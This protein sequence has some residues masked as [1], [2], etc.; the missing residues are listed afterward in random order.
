[1]ISIANEAMYN[2][3]KYNKINQFF[4]DCTYKM[5]PPNKNK[6][7]LMVL[8]GFN[9]VSKKLY[10]VRFVLLTNKKENTFKALF[11]IL[12]ENYHFNPRNIMC[13]FSLG[14]IKEVKEIYPYTNS[15]LFFSLF[16]SFLES[17]NE[18]YN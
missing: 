15:L 14:Q 13:D 3:I 8:S 7:K 16:Q 18:E 11:K 2:N 17:F 5:V 10:Y 9:I 6:F 1:M 4:F 12:K